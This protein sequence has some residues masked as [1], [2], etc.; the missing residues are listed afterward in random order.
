MDLYSE[1]ELSL[2]PGQFVEIKLD[3]FYLRRPIS[4]AYGDKHEL[5][6]IYKV[7]GKG[8]K[9]LS[10]MHDGKLDILYDL[11]NGYDLSLSG[12]KP[13]LIGGGVGV[14]PLYY[15][16]KQLIDLKK[17]V[18]VILGFNKKEE[19]F[20]EEEFKEL[21]CEVIVCTVDGS[22][23][24]KGFVTAPMS[25]LN[26]SYFYTCGPLPM[27]KAVYDGSSTEGQFSF[28]ERMGCG[29]GVCMGCTT[30]V[31]GGYKRICKEGPIL[32]K[33]EILW[34]D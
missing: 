16:A 4:V 3:G 34:E 32:N 19:V 6:I 28:E 17:E 27:L 5:V 11:G 33:E 18:T 25:D 23:G 26:Y 21:G 22:Y 1:K 12:K 2:N 30:K 7:V 13:L 24:T 8:T 29:Y 15:L 10:E 14:P 9:V 20:Y 31:K